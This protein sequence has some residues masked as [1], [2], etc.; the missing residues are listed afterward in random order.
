MRTDETP[1]VGLYD[2]AAVVGMDHARKL[3]HGLHEEEEARKVLQQQE[4]DKT[5][6]MDEAVDHFYNEECDGQITGYIPPGA[7]IYWWLR[8]KQMGGQVG[9]F[10]RDAESYKWFEKK[11]PDI[12]VRNRFRQER[13]GYT[14]K[15][16][17]G[18]KY[19]DVRKE[20]AA[21]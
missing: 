20:S 19:G 17:E 3:M 9:D 11:N 12:K 14:G 2:L 18:T 16:L 10:W 8:S 1:I 4:F 6:R 15:L 21:A 13:S 7:Y 5:G